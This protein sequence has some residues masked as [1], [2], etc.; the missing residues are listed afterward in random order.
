MLIL[1]IALLAL[2]YL[3]KYYTSGFRP[4][5]ASQYPLGW[6]GWADQGEYLKSIR[7]FATGAINSNYFLYPPLYA[8]LSA[9]FWLVSREHAVLVPDLIYCLVFHGSLLIVAR[10][11][12]GTVLP[13]LVCFA[14]LVTL[15]IMTID[16]WVIP[17]TTSLQAA[18][19][20]I[21]I[22]IFSTGETKSEPF[23]LAS[24][25]DWRLFG[26]FFI[27]Y[28]A[29][30]P[31]RPLDV[32]VWFPFALVYFLKTTIASIRG[33]PQGLGRV[34]VAAQCLMLAATCGALLV[35]GYLAFNLAVHHS[36]F[37][38]YGAL[39]GS[40]GY[41]PADL[42]EK[43]LSTFWNSEV[44]YGEARQALFERIPFFAPVFAVSLVTAVV[45]NDVRRWIVLTAL[46]NF[47]VY[48][49]YGDLLPTGFFRY[50]NLHYFKWAFP[51]LAVIAIGQVVVWFSRGAQRKRNWTPLAASA[52][53][54][55][56]GLSVGLRPTE[57]QA[58]LDSRSPEIHL[59]R[60]DAPGRRQV[61]FV[62]IKGL[63]G[64]FPS[65]YNGPHSL[66]VDGAAQPQSVFRLLPL[67]DGGRLMFVRPKAF[68]HLELTINPDLTFAP[69][70][71]HSALGSIQIG[72]SC[73]IQKCEG[74]PKLPWRTAETPAGAS[75][76]DFRPDGNMHDVQLTDWW[77]GETWGRWSAR[78]RTRLELMVRPGARFSVAA[79]AAP[80]IGGERKTGTLQLS[81]NGCE[82]TRARFE[83]AA[84]RRLAGEI[85]G[86]CLRPD[87]SMLVELQADAAGQSVDPKPRRL[88]VAIEDLTIQRL[89]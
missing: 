82:I 50:F 58:V 33:S 39:A 28:G 75:R 38:I 55:L 15:P 60:V 17:W 14:L 13:G 37:G 73:L 11:F 35:L 1:G 44:V 51:W 34:V 10:R 49:P 16:Q 48:L 19:L 36:L 20:G 5:P 31:T 40:K 46:L 32:V 76:F 45:V 25:K 21:M 72:A 84:R 3:G 52:A 2:L 23:R 68:S 70:E 78:A 79:T 42:P 56:L 8:L 57:R 67:A 89:P 7:A 85:P 22:L 69:G 18:L 64:G 62:D 63:G 30:A 43:I 41:F 61:D 29:L 27:V 9:P 71:N 54:V 87:G 74:P 24:A 77:D 59:I 81:V 88:G 53:L 83:T 80:F 6:W 66:V 26:A 86:R 12:Y 65:F 47:L 4:D